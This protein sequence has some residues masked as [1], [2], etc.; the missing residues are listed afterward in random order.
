VA[1]R[2]GP[3]PRGHPPGRAASVS[4]SVSQTVRQSS[5]HSLS[6]A[7]RGGSVSQPCSCAVSASV[8]ESVSESVNESVSQCQSVSWALRTDDGSSAV[9]SRAQP[10]PRSHRHRAHTRVRTAPRAPPSSVP[11]V[12]LSPSARARAAILPAPAA[13]GRLV[14]AAV[15]QPRALVLLLRAGATAAEGR[16]RPA[17]VRAVHAAVGIACAR[18]SCAC[19]GAR[20]QPRAEPLLPLRRSL[21]P[22]LS[23]IRS[24]PPLALPHL[25]LSPRSRV[26]CTIAF[27]RTHAP[28]VPHCARARASAACAQ[29]DLA[30]TAFDRALALSADS[31]SADVWCARKPHACSQPRSARRACLRDRWPASRER[32]LP[33][34]L[35]QPRAR[36]NTS[37]SDPPHPT[38]HRHPPLHLLA[39][40]PPCHPP[41]RRAGT[42]SRRWR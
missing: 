41:P 23:G 2:A 4:Q 19:G 36:A 33:A 3:A 1:V 25:S 18:S 29:Y 22:C 16:A 11:N 6:L 39:S 34:A 24:Y 37:P 35:A 38:C 5:T 15:E 32:E 17:G 42:T 8:S 7:V 28:H 21:S 30:L 26:S 40:S 31:E 13:A 27:A 10:P 12:P 20:L 14:G 9:H